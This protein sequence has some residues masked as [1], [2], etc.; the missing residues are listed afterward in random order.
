MRLLDTH[1][2]QFV[3]RDTREQ[4]LKYAILSHTWDAGGEQT[5]KELKKIQK[6]YIGECLF[7]AESPGSGGPAASPPL[8]AIWKDSDLSP[9]ILHACAVARN[10][11]YRYL[12]VDSCCIDKTSSS[13]LSEAINSM[14]AWYQGADVCYSYLADVPAKPDTREEG[15]AF[16]RSRWFERGWTLQELIAPRNLIFLSD[17]WTVL[18]SKEGFADLVNA[19]TGISV[20][21]LCNRR[22]L[23]E[24]SVAQRLSWAARRE[25]TRVED[26]AYSLLGI[27]DIHMPTLYGEGERAFQRLQEE[28]L[29]RVSDQ[30][31]FACRVVS[32]DRK[33]QILRLDMLNPG[34][35]L[36]PQHPEDTSPQHS[37]LPTSPIKCDTAAGTTLFSTSPDDF[38]DGQRI[39]PVGRAYLLY[40]FPDLP[41]PDY[42]FTPHGIRTHIALIP[43][44]YC[45]PGADMM[46]GEADS[47]WYLAV[48]GCEH[49]DYPG[50]LLGRVCHLGTTT[51]GVN[52]L[53]P[54]AIR[55]NPS[56]SVEGDTPPAQT[57]SGITFVALS[58]EALVRLSP[59]ANVVPVHL[60]RPSR[61]SIRS[62]SSDGNMRENPHKTMNLM[63]KK[64]NRDDSSGPRMSLRW[65]DQ[66]NPTTHWL[67]I[68]RPALHCAADV[69]DTIIIKYTHT[70][71]A[72]GSPNV[73][74]FQVDVSGTLQ[75]HPITHNSLLWRDCTPWGYKPG[76]RDVTSQEHRSIVLKTKEGVTQAMQLSL[77]YLAPD[78]YL[79]DAWFD[80][81]PHSEQ[82]GNTSESALLDDKATAVVGRGTKRSR[83]EFEEGSSGT[84]ADLED[85]RT[86]KTRTSRAA[87]WLPFGI[88]S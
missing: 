31:I 61:D 40:H 39:Q 62:R 8:S 80:E 27:F 67:T 16:R 29:R 51:P 12:W 5:H 26:R 28:I 43:L 76:P 19:V 70:L 60:S 57:G 6:R 3:E 56:A 74:V 30:S 86:S 68:S 41:V 77:E 79:I 2:G 46:Y 78:H 84:D 64:K 75:G 20:E 35:E 85:E 59:L 36:T 58:A 15:S 50:N 49:V 53:S 23:S 66:H 33:S 18:G 32:Q 69:L 63:L 21:V 83:A 7:P 4:G 82:D 52:L 38:V 1:T 55:I 47:E 54:G 71:N 37:M 14:Y 22:S 65:P 45:L 72:G 73:V 81:S 44:T 42:N 13:E 87:K 25:T 48:L 34:L 24:F 10:D 88:S 17:R 11:G 9:K